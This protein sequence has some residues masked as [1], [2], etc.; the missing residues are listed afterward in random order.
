MKTEGERYRLAV[1]AAILVLALPVFVAV[2]SNSFRTSTGGRS[3]EDTISM[4]K[5][6]IAQFKYDNAKAYLEKALAA[7]PNDADALNLM[8]FTARKLGDPRQSLAYYNKALAQNP[9]H[10]G[11]N[12]Y[13]GELYLEM[14]DVKKAEERL[15]VLQQACGGNCEEYQDLKGKIDQFKLTTS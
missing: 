7:A 3:A 11:A 6:A 2:A 13:L 5:T 10:L 1:A 12:E 9:S 15:S 4:A 8:G 14:K